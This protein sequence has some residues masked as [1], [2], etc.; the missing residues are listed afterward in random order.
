MFGSASRSAR[1]QNAKTP[2]LVRASECGNRSPLTVCDRPRKLQT[3]LVKLSALSLPVGFVLGLSQLTAC[4]SGANE[5][6]ATEAICAPIA[7]TECPDPAPHYPDVAPIFES[8]CASC[9][10][11]IGD[12]PWPL[13]T[14]EKVA[15][16]A[17][18]VRSRLLNC[19]MP[20]ADSG[21]MMMPEERDRILAW[22]RCG[23]LE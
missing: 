5:G 12:A 3:A 7:P 13:D 4:S 15:D 22:V 16:W 8:R 10:T 2:I 19:S 11:G 17:Y 14:Y 18:V 21:V 9:H 1:S 23:F 20:P 6:N